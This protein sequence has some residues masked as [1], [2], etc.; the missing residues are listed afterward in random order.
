M[1]RFLILLLVV[2]LLLG[3]CAC[4]GGETEAPKLEGFHAGYGRASLAGPVGTPLAGY[5]DGLSRLS[6]GILNE[7]FATCIAMTDD[8]GKTVLLYTADTICT[9]TEWVEDM[10]AAIT[11][12]TGVP[13]DCIQL[14][15][16]HTHA[17]PDI[18]DSLN[19]ESAY[20]K[21][22]YLPAF[23]NAGK[24]AMEDRAPATVFSGDTLVEGLN[25]VR[26]YVM[27]DG[28][29]AGDNF[30]DAKNHKAVKN[31][32][33][34]DNQVQLIRFA[35]QEKKDIVMINFQ[36]H[37]KLASTAAMPYGQANRKMQSSDFVGG[38]REYVEANADVL[39]AYYQ[40]AAG[41]IN[42][43]DYYILLQNTPA[44]TD[45]K[46]YG[47][48]L[49]GAV[50][51]AMDS[52]TEMA[53]EPVLKTKQTIFM[54]DPKKGGEK[55][56]MELD[57]VVLGNIGFVTAP[58]E[59]F[60]TNGKQIKDGS[61]FKTTFVITYANGRFGYIGSDETWDY[62]TADGSVAY[63]IGALGYVTRGTGEKLAQEYI[64]M[65]KE[66]NG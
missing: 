28:N 21:N 36:A 30:G 18:R 31:H 23:V 19:K 52:L 13:A 57:A 47:K 4:S 22:I 32:H 50:I 45:L 20:Y 43:L 8:A 48:A 62:K 15:A 12:A 6:E 7:L 10:R 65:L 26:H 37:P 2:T 11:E 46:A 41:N 35:R 34:A 29:M 1:K 17:G 49:G 25:F 40:G 33:E 58:Y 51:E 44:Q 42:P 16:T 9:N 27:D 53:A 3:L 39:F 54:A 24:Q 5:G 63:E 61:P 64:S 55:L 59:M 38:T 66:L 56:A 60:D 14:T